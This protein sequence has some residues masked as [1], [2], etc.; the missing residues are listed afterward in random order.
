MNET[1]QM[2][3][4]AAAQAQANQAQ[5][6]GVVQIALIAGPGGAMQI[7]VNSSLPDSLQALGLI[8]MG[9]QQLIA[10]AQQPAGPKLLRASGNVPRTDG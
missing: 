9:K 10:Q 4:A 2:I 5:V 1:K 6:L 7:S 3:D 8:E